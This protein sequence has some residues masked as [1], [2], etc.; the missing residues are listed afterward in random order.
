M[1]VANRVIRGHAQHGRHVALLEVPDA[2]GREDLLD[3]TGERDRVVEVI[4]H[5]DRGDDLC[6]TGVGAAVGRGREEIRH[7]CDIVGI[8]LAELCAGR[9]DANAMKTTDTICLQQGGVIAADI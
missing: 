8:V 9:I 3:L 2:V 4:E 1:L 5:G 7:E 6:R